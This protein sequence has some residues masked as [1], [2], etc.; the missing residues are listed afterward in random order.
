MAWQSAH[1]V[2]HGFV[3]YYAAA[4]ALRSGAFG[5]WVYDDVLFGDYVRQVAAAGVREI[6]VPNT[7]TMSLLATPVAW[8]PPDTARAVWLAASL[9]AFAVSVIRVAQRTAPRGSAW[10][11][12]AVAAAMVNPSV[13]QN[14]QT[15][16]GYLLLAAG[17]A[18]ATMAML[19][20]HDRIAGITLGVLLAIK[21]SLAPLLALPLWHRR[22]V[23]VLSALAAA[24]CCVVAALPFTGVVVWTAWPVAVRAFVARPATGATAY[25]TLTGLTAHLC[26]GTAHT[27]AWTRSC[28]PAV[29]ALPF[30]LIFIAAIVTI[31]RTRDADTERIVAAGLALSLLALP[32]AEDHAFVLAMPAAFLLLREDHRTGYLLVVAAAFWLVPAQYSWARYTSGWWSVLAYPRLYATVLLWIASLLPNQRDDEA[33]GVAVHLGLSG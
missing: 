30:V 2:T 26:Q 24:V 28:G 9:V 4:H 21:P 32:I 16:Q 29:T 12:L 33:P 11:P 5:P 27:V 3:S 8:L 7:P 1:T 14:V 31:R 13:L 15:A 19:D 18:V 20:R 10:G 25:Q 17:V 23:V 6:F 22:F